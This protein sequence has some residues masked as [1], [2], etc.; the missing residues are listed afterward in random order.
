[1]AV[2]AAL[3][4]TL[5]LRVWAPANLLLRIFGTD[6]DGARLY[7]MTTSRC[8][9][10]EEGNNSQQRGLNLNNSAMGSAPDG[11]QGQTQTYQYAPVDVLGDWVI[12]G[13][14]FDV[15]PVL[16]ADMTALMEGR[17]SV[18]NASVAV[19][20][21]LDEVCGEQCIRFSR[22]V[23]LLFEDSWRRFFFGVRVECMPVVEFVPV[24]A[25]VDVLPVLGADMTGLMDGRIPGS[26]AS[27]AVLTTLDEV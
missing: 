13:A 23:I 3:T 21:T 20:T 5:T 4:D 6:N 2:N 22:L 12:A 15:L 7:S 10:E 26:N 25:D 9:E 17:I 11:P 27:V 16:G 24:L 19:L 8:G 14:P 18:S 1:M